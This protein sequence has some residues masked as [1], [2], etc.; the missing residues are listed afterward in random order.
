MKLSIH[1]P[2]YLPWLSYFLKIEKSDNFVFLDNVNFQKNGLQNR[3]KI[4]NSNGEFWLTVPILHNTGQ[5]IID[6]KINNK[7]NWKK[8]HM[9]ALKYSYQ[10]SPFFEKYFN[11]I[12]EIYDLN[13]YYLNDL[14]ICL[15][16]K[17][18]KWMEIKT[19]IKRSSEINAEGISSDLI[20]NICLKIGA[21]EYISGTGGKNYLDKNKF[22][23][24]GVNI[25]QAKPVVPNIYPQQFHK[26]GFNNSLS[27]IDLLFNCGNNWRSY[28]PIDES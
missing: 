11:E 20:L 12:I 1:Q 26:V 19:I 7:I 2:Q 3:N 8:K 22:Q 13:W 25:L 21:D 14:N 17:I 28:L 9:N 5:K 23:D 6:V 27:V 24:H 10:K 18:L 15:I 4:K 16:E